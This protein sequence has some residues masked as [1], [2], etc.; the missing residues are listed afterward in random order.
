MVV[1]VSPRKIPFIPSAFNMFLVILDGPVFVSFGVVWLCSCSWIF[2]SSI[3]VITRLWMAPAPKPPNA[4]L[5]YDGGCV[6]DLYGSN[7]RDNV[8]L[9]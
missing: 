2:I 7:A 5:P 1:M 8:A 4:T 3:G 9:H 6:A